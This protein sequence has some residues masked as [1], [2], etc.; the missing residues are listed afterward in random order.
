[1]Q[2]QPLR[3]RDPEGNNA[4]AN[5]SISWEESCSFWFVSSSIQLVLLDCPRTNSLQWN[6]YDYYKSQFPQIVLLIDSRLKNLDR[7]KL[8]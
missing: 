6:Y 3:K 8:V 7:E 5:Q 1:M 4:S 2:K